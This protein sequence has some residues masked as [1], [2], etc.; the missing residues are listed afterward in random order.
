MFIF[1]YVVLHPNASHPGFNRM[2]WQWTKILELIASLLLAVFQFYTLQL[3]WTGVHYLCTVLTHAHTLSDLWEPLSCSLKV[4]LVIHLILWSWCQPVGL[5]NAKLGSMCYRPVERR[6][7][8]NF[9]LFWNVQPFTQCTLSQCFSLANCDHNKERSTACTHNNPPWS[10]WKPASPLGFH[11]LS[12]SG[13]LWMG[14]CTYLLLPFWISGFDLIHA[15][16]CFESD[17]EITQ[18]LNTACFPPAE[19][20]SFCFIQWQIFFFYERTNQ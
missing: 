7:G 5:W 19:E 15:A 6:R 3:T 11:W 20:T 4:P 2:S 10:M 14:V 13:S 16:L 17:S 1:G 8:E 12:V 18:R 9:S